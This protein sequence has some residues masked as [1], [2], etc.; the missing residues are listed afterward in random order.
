MTRLPSSLQE[1]PHLS[2]WIDFGQ[3]GVVRV[4]TAKVELGQGIVTAMAQVAAEELR[5]PLQKVTV[6]SG[7][8]RYS[9]KESYTAGSMSIEVGGTSLGIA[10][11]RARQ[12]IVEAAARMLDAD[13][14]RVTADDGAILLDGS[15]S[16]L[17]YW[18]VAP[19]LDLSSR[20]TRAADFGG[21]GIHTYILKF[22][23]AHR[24]VISRTA[25]RRSRRHAVLHGT[26]TN[27][28]WSSR[29]SR[30]RIPRPNAGR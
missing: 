14:S 15:P 11:A 9:P 3:P 26:S 18:S 23:D 1:N 27:D 17:D 29:P 21:E 16:G 25:E 2:S 30:D 10:C 20:I 7:D 5:L 22:S 8:T 24:V 28:C 6:I 12:A 13:V 19:K 4:F